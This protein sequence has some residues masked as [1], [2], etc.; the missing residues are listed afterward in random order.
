MSEFEHN[1]KLLQIYTSTKMGNVLGDKMNFKGCEAFYSLQGASD[2]QLKNDLIQNLNTGF[3][4]IE[5]W[6][7][8][9]ED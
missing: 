5:Y 6:N 7:V 2:L 4:C 8:W 9:K 3:G 1:G